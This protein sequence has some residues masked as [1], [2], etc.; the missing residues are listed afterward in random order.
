MLREAE[1]AW[2]QVSTEALKEM[3]DDTIMQWEI[4]K[5]FVAHYE[6]GHREHAMAKLWLQWVAQE[7][8]SIHLTVCSRTGSHHNLN[9]ITEQAST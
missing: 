1:Y 2:R 6:D 9:S 8:M 3:L 7:A 4:G 5:L